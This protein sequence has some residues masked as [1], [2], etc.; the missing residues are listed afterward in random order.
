MATKETTQKQ[1]ESI[2][3]KT[4]ESVTVENLT[5]LSGG[6]SAETWLFDVTSPKETQQLILRSSSTGDVAFGAGID[7]KIEAQLQQ[8]AYEAG[9]PVAKVVYILKEEDQL[10]MGYVMERHQG[11]TIARKILRDEKFSEARSIMAAQCGEILAKIHA[12]DIA[13]LPK[14]P[15]QAAKPQLEQMK[16]LYKSFNEAV[17]VFDLACQWLADN[18]PED[19]SLHLVHGDFRNGNFIVNEKGI[20]T[21]LDW[22]LSHFGD[23]M[24]DLGWLC[25]NSWRFGEINKPVGGFGQK[26]DLFSAYEKHSGKQ[27]NEESVKF[28]EVFGTFK[29]GVICLYQTFAHLNNQVRSVERA[30][31]GRRVSE[32]EIDLLRLIAPRK[33]L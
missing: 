19:E 20:K 23:P 27:V 10:G 31:I 30:A 24:E 6:A 12:I 26:E 9:V 22:E 21:V 11:E 29:W 16:A 15:D 5:P 3:R 33:P 2:F 28:W 7:K 13:I 8:K 14:L 32:T 1:L 18:L 25:V 17:P 4:K